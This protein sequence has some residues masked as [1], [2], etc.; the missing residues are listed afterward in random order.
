MS[1]GI[2][3]GAILGGIVVYVWMVI[4][5]MVLP[6]N[7]DNMKHFESERQ[8]CSVLTENCKMDGEYVLNACNGQMPF[9]YTIVKL[10]GQ[11]MGASNYIISLI[12]QIVGAGFFSF[13]LSRTSG[14]SYVGKLFFVT[15]LG[16]MVWWLNTVPMWNWMGLSAAS[17]WAMLANLGIGWFLAGLVMAKVVHTK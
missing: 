6:W 7:R 3:K 9:A 10:R 16:V 5:Y 15:F 14:M 1:S 17:T 12:I 11:T 8:V 2:I 4:A 13:F